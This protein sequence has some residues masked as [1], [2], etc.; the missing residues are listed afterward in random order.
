MGVSLS[1]SFDDE[2]LGEALSNA[3]ARARDLS[4]PLNSSAAYIE[5][6]V[7]D[8]FETGIG[9]DGIRWIPS[10]RAQEQGGLTL[11][12]KAR[13]RGSIKSN[14]GDDFL[15]TGS[16]ATADS[17]RYAR[18]HQ[19]GAT[20]RPKN[21]EFLIFNG[22]NGGLVFAREVNIPARPFLGIDDADVLELQD[23]W[24]QWVGGLIDG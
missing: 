21:G 19:F 7:Q 20:I 23:I 12:D 13:L 11:V 5:A 10:K 22:A 3:V 1:I 6:S 24:D 14:V 16:D 9:P 8:R 17:A 15:E 18:T 4:A 2:G